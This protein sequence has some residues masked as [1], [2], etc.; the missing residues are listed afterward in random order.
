MGCEYKAKQ[1]STPEMHKAALHAID[2]LWWFCDYED[3]EYRAKSNSSITIHK[4]SK[5]NIG[6][7]WK[8][9]P[10]C[11]HKAKKKAHLDKHI[12]RKYTSK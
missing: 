2:V 7:K 1:E 5:H 6:V 10:H 3:C 11:D 4:A 8:Q 9:C 12:Q